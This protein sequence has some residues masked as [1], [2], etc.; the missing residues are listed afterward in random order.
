MIFN[1]VINFN[2][3]QNFCFFYKEMIVNYL[4]NYF[5]LEY[6]FSFVILSVYYKS[7]K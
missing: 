7:N 2:E 5:F 4:K 1:L 6:K 3:R